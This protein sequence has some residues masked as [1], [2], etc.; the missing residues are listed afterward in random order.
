MHHNATHNAS[1]T[2]TY[3]SWAAMLSR[4]RYAGDPRYPQYRWYVGVSVCAEW[5]PQ[6]GGSFQAF[7]E[8]MGEKLEGTSLD[9]IDGD[10]D[11]EPGN[12]RWATPAQQSHNL[13]SNV[14]LTY[15]GKRLTLAEAARAAGI[16]PDTLGLRYRKG[17]RGDHLFRPTAHTGRRAWKSQGGQQSCAGSSP[18]VE[19][20]N[21]SAD[22]ASD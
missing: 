13:K 2:K 11:Y 9:R 3:K 5:D 18:V 12:C 14:F 8:H 1:K 20:S 16:H 21:E 15:Q 7:L 10:K 19:R 6:K 17:E 22:R 4:C